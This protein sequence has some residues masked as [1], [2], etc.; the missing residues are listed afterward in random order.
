MRETEFIRKNEKKWAEYEAALKKDKQDPKKLGELYVHTTD[1]LSYSRT[2][3]PNRSV[4]VYLNGLAQRTFLQIYKGRRGEA[5]RFITFWTDELPRILYRH[6]R[7]LLVALILF[8]ISMAVGVISY[9]I[10]PQFAEFILGDG[11]VAMTRE[12]IRSGDPMAIYKSQSEFD[13]FLAITFNNIYVAFKTFVMGAF[14]AV[15]SIFILMSNGV[16]VGVFQYFFVDQELFRESFLTIWIHGALEISSIVIAGGAGLVMGS[17]LLFPGTYSRVRAF[18]RSARDGFKIMLGTVP[19]F[20]IAGFLESFLTR[21]TQLDDSL[22]LVFILLCFAFILWY[23]WYYPRLV[24]TRQPEA[25]APDRHAT[26][27]ER[28]ATD[29][30]LEPNRIKMIGEI[31]TE[32]MLVLGRNIG[33]VLGGLALA[34]ITFCGLTITLSG[35]RIENLFV[36]SNDPVSFFYNVYAMLSTL[37]FEG[38]GV[39][40]FLAV[41]AGFYLLVLMGGRL[42]GRSI[43]GETPRRLTRG[44]LLASLL[45]ALLLAACFALPGGWMALAIFLVL[46]F[47]CLYAYLA[48]TGQ[49]DLKTAFR[50]CYTFLLSNYG[51]F[52]LLGLLGFFAF[53]LLDTSIT[54]LVFGL[55]NWMISG[56]SV[57]LY[58]INV[59][60]QAFL[61]FT[62]FGLMLITWIIALGLNFHSN[63]ERHEA[64]G[65][66]EAIKNVGRERRLRGLEME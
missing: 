8:A 46:P 5:R 38:R 1:D 13:M 41:V 35:Q 64:L 16:M 28:L 26:R 4:R 44:N 24:V 61:Y 60:V 54:Q 18:G 6:R 7:S 62:Y 21:Q 33:R 2:F 32:T 30:N 3:Y 10:D 20:V 22:R 51:L 12:N 55:L 58:A 57:L 53:F 17:G 63:R 36:F 59:V 49:S 29:L 34:A 37:G 52:L 39:G 19:L 43:L 25:D 50:Y 14:F 66:K 48:A 45:P 65:L 27:N 56:N 42:V 47:L 40:F 31:L 9:R 15:G 23:Y 11:Y